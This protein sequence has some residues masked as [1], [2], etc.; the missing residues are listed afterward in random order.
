VT[1]LADAPRARRADD[2]AFGWRIVDLM[3]AIH[4]RVRI[5]RLSWTVPYLM[6]VP[7]V[8]LVCLFVGGLIDLIFSGFHSYDAF[9]GL[10]GELSLEQYRRLF[11]GEA[12]HHYIGTI[13][14]TV[15]MSVIVTVTAIALALPLA[16]FI[17]QIR[18]RRWRFVSMILLLVPFLMGEIV[19]AFGWFILVG[20]DGVLDW[21]GSLLGAGSVN[22]LGT[23]FAV[24]LGMLQV[25]LP[26]AVLVLLPSLKNVS[27]DLERAASTL[28]A[29][30][31]R[32]WLRIIIPLSR[33]GM[34]SAATVVFSLSMTEFAIPQVLGLGKVPFVANDVST[35]FFFQSNAYLGSALSTVLLV[36]VLVGVLLLATFGTSQRKASKS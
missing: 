32:I 2:V 3:V 17:L 15:L 31:L 27:P 12:S 26:F 4:R 1:D 35:I 5:P 23:K 28:G 25:M 34:V 13:R 33:Q 9:R 7:A 14:T 21:I 16:Y 8:V 30:P 36:L 10:E 24:W 29:R 19:R 20:R 6:I 18:S 22:L 11:T